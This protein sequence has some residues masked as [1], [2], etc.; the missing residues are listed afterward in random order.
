MARISRAELE[1]RGAQLA[2]ELEASERRVK[3]LTEEVNSLQ[4]EIC[5]IKEELAFFREKAKGK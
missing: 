3:E 5:S 1:T 4:G 2:F